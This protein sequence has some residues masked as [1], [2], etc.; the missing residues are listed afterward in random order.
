MTPARQEYQTYT[1]TVNDF[2]FYNGC[3]DR[4]SARGSDGHSRPTSM[5]ADSYA[6]EY[7]LRYGW[8]L[9]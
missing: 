9:A 2:F 8:G 7:A 1:D 3:P 4:S 6:D 5:F